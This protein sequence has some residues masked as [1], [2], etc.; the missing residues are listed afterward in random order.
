MYMPPLGVCPERV[1]FSD[2]MYKRVGI[3]NSEVEVYENVE[4][5]LFSY[6]EGP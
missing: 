3:F 1:P 4:N 2:F 6:L 5:L